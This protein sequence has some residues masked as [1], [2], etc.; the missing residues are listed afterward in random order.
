MLLVVPVIASPLP[1]LKSAPTF[2][3]ITMMNPGG[4]HIAGGRAV[5]R[6]S[7]S[8]QRTLPSDRHRSERQTF[9]AVESAPT[10]LATAVWAMALFPSCPQSLLPRSQRPPPKAAHLGRLPSRAPAQQRTPFPS[11]L[12]SVV[13]LRQAATTS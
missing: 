4:V 11:A 9:P 12:R 5:C 8:S 13:V 1:W 6:T 2:S 10:P 7:A 3:F